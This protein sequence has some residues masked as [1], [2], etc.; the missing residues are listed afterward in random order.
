MIHVPFFDLLLTTADGSVKE[1]T[2]QI[3]TNHEQIIL[4]LIAIIATSIAALV[5]TIRN[6]TMIKTTAQDASDVNKAVNNIGPGEHRLYDMISM[7][8]DDMKHISEAQEE[9]SKKGWATLPPDIATASGLT[10][11]IRNLQNT[12]KAL[13]EKMDQ[14]LKELDSHVKWEMSQ[15]YP[16]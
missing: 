15:K 5:Y 9:F 2:S 7:V 13:H 11:V 16:K 14:I 1:A 8:R 3:A 6:N 12:D 4:A 10:E